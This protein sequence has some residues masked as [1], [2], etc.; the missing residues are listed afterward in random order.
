MEKD[1]RGTPLYGEAEA[2]YNT[3][4]QPGTGQISDAADVHVSPD[5]RSVVFAG[6]IVKNI[7]GTTTTRICSTDLTSGRTHVLTFGPNT[8]RLE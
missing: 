7:A 6:T 3:L 5:G 2:L 8:N 4:R 1:I